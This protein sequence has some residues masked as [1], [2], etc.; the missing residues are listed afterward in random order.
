MGKVAKMRVDIVEKSKGNM[1]KSIGKRSGTR[2]KRGER[3]NIGQLMN[4]ERGDNVENDG[5]LQMF[6]N[7]MIKGWGYEPLRSLSGGRIKV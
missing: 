3:V 2:A 7:M 4:E 1:R 6:G 5:H